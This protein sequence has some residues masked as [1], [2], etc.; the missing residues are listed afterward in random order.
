MSTYSVVVNNKAFPLSTQ[1]NRLLHLFN[2]SF[3][4]VAGIS[5]ELCL[6]SLHKFHW[7][8]KQKRGEQK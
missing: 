6:N 4:A 5:G 8:K 2:L 7:H 3:I 1:K